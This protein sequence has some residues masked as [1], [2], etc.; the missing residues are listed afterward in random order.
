ML[1]FLLSC[2][3][4][5]TDNGGA[6]SVTINFPSSYFTD[7]NLVSKGNASPV[8]L[9][10]LTSLIDATPAKSKIHLAIYGFDH[11][12][13]ISSL[14]KA[15][16][17]NVEIHIAIDF[18]LDE[19]QQQNRPTIITIR[20]FLKEG[21]DITTI[22]NDAGS[23]AIQHNK[24][25]LFSDINTS[26]GIVNNVVFQTSHNF[27]IDDSKKLQDAVVLNQKGLYDAYLNYFNQI[28]SR[29]ASGM[30]D[31]SFLEFNDE[32]NG[33]YA[34]YFPKRKNGV[35]YGGDSIIEFLDAITDPASTTISVG[36]S[37]WT[38]SRLNVVNKLQELLL[39][40]AKVEVVAKSKADPE[41]LTGLE[42]LRKK[43]AFVKI[44]NLT[45]SSQPKINI[46]SKF[47]IIDGAW[48]GEKCKIVATGSHNLTGNA[49][50]NNNETLLIL[51]NFNGLFSDYT[52]NFLELKKLP[53][54]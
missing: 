26:T 42:N 54:I 4:S 39:K 23:S 19:T 25:V 32:P 48:K 49:L 45:L 13:V 43:G 40:G 44:L 29:G 46:H 22:N 6:N 30:K 16:E 10:R 11:Q 3:K 2:K 28:K 5:N 38:A 34:Q 36:M 52:N 50:R 33:I 35:A 27:T 8:I 24:F 47:F 17:R 31:F 1:L 53:G 51:K 21:S 37:D 9:D 18:S 41:I 7:V 12:G 15:A 14:K 20:S